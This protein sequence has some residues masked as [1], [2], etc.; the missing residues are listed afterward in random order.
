MQSRR[1]P[2]Q[3]GLAFEDEPQWSR[4]SPDE[5]ERCVRLLVQMI[6][7]VVRAVEGPSDAEEVRDE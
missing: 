3:M 7:A 4:V 1:R 2:C 6:L 5:R